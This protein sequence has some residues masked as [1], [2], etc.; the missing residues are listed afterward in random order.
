MG[1]VRRHILSAYPV[2]VFPVGVPM[3]QISSETEGERLSNWLA[4]YSHDLMEEGDFDQEATELAKAAQWIA[5]H[6]A[7]AQK[8]KEPVAWRYQRKEGWEGIWR[9][10]SL[11]ITDQDFETPEDWVTEP[12][13][14]SDTSTDCEGK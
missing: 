8:P 6:L 3:S 12:L 9:Y 5:D 1:R 11:P 13:Y 4:D 7:L 2:R 14:V 10:S